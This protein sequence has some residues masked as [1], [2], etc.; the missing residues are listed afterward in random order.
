MRPRGVTYS[1]LSQFIALLML[2]IR[3]ETQ[4]ALWDQTFQWNCGTHQALD[5][6][7]KTLCPS[8]SRAA[9]VS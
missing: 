6:G 7:R 3:Q 4:F 9:E 1:I 8:E 5:A 2:A